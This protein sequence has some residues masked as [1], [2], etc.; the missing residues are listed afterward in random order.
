MHIQFIQKG[1]DYIED[2]LFL[3]ISLE[4]CAKAAGYSLYHYCRVFTS[5]MGI[6][7]KE[8]IRRRRVS[9]SVRMINETSL[10]LKEIGYRCGFNSQENYIR[11]FKTVFGISPVEYKKSRYPMLLTERGTLPGKE[12][13][14]PDYAS[15]QPP[16]IMTI[17]SFTVAGRSNPTTFEHERQFQDV[18]VFWDQFYSQRLYERLGFAPEDCRTDHGVSILNGDASDLYDEQG[19]RRGLDFDYLTGVR[20][21]DTLKVPE[22]LDSVVIPSG[23]YAVFHHHPAN[24]Y[25]LIQNLIDTWRYIDFYWLP[26][27]AYEHAGS[28]EFNE[29]DP[30]RNRLSKTIYIPV[31]PKS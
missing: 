11:V 16:R 3:T 21:P 29:Y 25:N 20:I 2:N 26:N 18:P 1:I 6:P 8:Y 31:Q 4:E 7:V 22:D 28:L 5:V 27:S 19:Q 30:Q 14:E 13:K 15:F 9:E 17:R 24:D 12:L 23:L 10:S